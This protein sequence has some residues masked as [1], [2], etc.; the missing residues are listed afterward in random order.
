VLEPYVEKSP[1]AF[2]GQR[3]VVGKRLMQAASDIFL[4]WF[5]G[6]GGHD[7]YVRQLRDMK[8]SFPVDDYT[9]VELERYAEL[10][11]WTLAR[12]HAKSGD[13]ATIAGY[14]GGGNKFESALVKF[15]SAYANQTEQDHA[16]LLEAVRSGRVDAV[17][18]LELSSLQS[19]SRAG[20]VRPS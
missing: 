17:D 16:A 19:S 8:Y 18:D 6:R 2:E 9:A 5:R 14:L 12:A 7:F 20:T 13:A 11:G 10:C 1:F 15:A 4:G 3:V